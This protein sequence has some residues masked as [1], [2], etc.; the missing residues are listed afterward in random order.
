[1]IV[2]Y[3]NPLEWFLVFDSLKI[4][5][6]NEQIKIKTVTKIKGKALEKK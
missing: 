3:E 1:M 6:H 5:N 4:I 2:I